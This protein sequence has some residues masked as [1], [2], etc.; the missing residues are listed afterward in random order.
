MNQWIIETE[1]LDY[2]FRKDEKILDDINLRVPQGSVYGFLGPN[3]AGKTTT[4]RLLLGLLRSE[5]PNIRLLGR[6]MPG[7]RIDILRRTGS[8]IEQPSLYLHLT[9]LENLE[10]FRRAYECPASRVGEVLRITRLS[11]AAHKRTRAYSLG[12]KQRLGIAIALL[13]DPEVL[14]MDEPT[15]GL[16]PNGIIEIRELIR[17]LNR[18]EGK[19]VLVSS[20]LLTEVEKL[21]TH[22]GIIHKG[23]LLFQGTLAELQNFQYRR[24]L[25]EIEVDNVT[26]AEQILSGRFSVSVNGGSTIHVGHT[27]PDEAALINHMLVGGGVGVSRLS[28]TGNDLEKLFLDI[29]SA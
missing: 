29:I 12:M 6:Q 16:D 17:D 3:G 8:L 24:A 1:H 26:R 28:A 14:I 15:N 20:H 4:L 18:Q 7:S 23:K 11:D 21:A 2:G 19:T 13:H 25:L 9:G 5:N 10:V 22:V 27:K